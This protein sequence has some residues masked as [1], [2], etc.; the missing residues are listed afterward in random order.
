MSKKHRDK[1]AATAALHFYFTQAVLKVAEDQEFNVGEEFLMGEDC[2]ITELYTYT[3]NI[4]TTEDAIQ[5]ER[6]LSARFEYLE[7]LAECFWQIYV[8]QDEP[9]EQNELP[10]LEHFS[11]DVNRTILSYT[12]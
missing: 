1:I 7:E 5:G 10:D 2:F 6:P 12:E 9:E 11:L 8:L 4:E 3:K